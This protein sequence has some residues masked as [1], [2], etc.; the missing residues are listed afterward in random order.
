MCVVGRDKKAYLDLAVV[1]EA[2]MVSGG[3]Q[4]RCSMF[5][6]C[7]L[8]SFGVGMEGHLSFTTSC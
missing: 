7:I 5:C 8:I 1:N 4:R 3:K 6:V 2:S